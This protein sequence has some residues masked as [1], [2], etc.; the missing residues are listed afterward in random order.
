MGVVGVGH[1]GLGMALR[2]L[3]LGYPVHVRDID[4]ARESLALQHGATVHADAES[5]ARVS[6]ALIVAVVDGAQTH[7]VLFGERGAA[8]GLAPG[9]T[10]LL[11]PTIS[12]RDVEGTAAAL[13]RQGVDCIDAP[14]SGGPARARDGTMSLMVACA[15]AV[16]ERWQ[17]LLGDLST[18]LCRIGPVPGDGAR[19]KLVNNLLAAVNLAGAAEAMALAQQLGL[20]PAVTLAVIEQSSGQ[21]WIGSDRMRRALAGDPAVHA[22]MAL[23]AKDSALALDAARQAGFDA[24]LGRAAGACFAAAIAAGLQGQDDSTLWLWLRPAG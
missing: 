21:S 20:D 7:Q 1:M 24:R 2:L 5:V 22:Q 15:D 9:T 23:L 14:M 12:P 18:R 17:G 4:A 11:C 8:H 19:T 6:A 10:V 3:D 13:E 16:F